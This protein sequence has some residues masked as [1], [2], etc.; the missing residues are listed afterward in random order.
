MGVPKTLFYRV[1]DL[2]RTMAKSEKHC[3]LEHL[4]NQ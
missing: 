3:D 1:Q 2:I 4:T